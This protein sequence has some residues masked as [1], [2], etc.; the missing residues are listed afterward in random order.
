MAAKELLFSVTKK[1]LRVDTFRAGGK[2]GQNQNVRETGVR[3]TH[4][5]SGVSAESRTYRTQ[6]ENKK[7]AFR[8][9]VDNPRFKAWLKTEAA[10]L[11]NESARLEDIKSIVDRM[12][13]PKNLKIE[14]RTDGQWQTEA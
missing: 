3:F 10:R 2:G 6:E 7:A 14:V 8:K 1:D 12:M 13:S 9:L 5:A 11:M 4:A